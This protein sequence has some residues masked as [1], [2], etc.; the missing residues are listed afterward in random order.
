MKLSKQF[1]VRPIGHFRSTLK[2]RD[3]APHQGWEGAP[4]ASIEIDVDFQEALEGLRVGQELWILTW[5]HE[6]ARE[7]LKVHPRGDTGNP[8][9]G[10]F[11]TRAPDRPNPIGLH[12]VTLLGISDRGCL[13]VQHVD[14]V[15]STPILDIKPVIERESDF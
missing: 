1:E 9:T 11:A 3:S 15:D 14:A 12:R 6:S 2:N 7:I 4:N 13:E 8:L 5:L 10:V